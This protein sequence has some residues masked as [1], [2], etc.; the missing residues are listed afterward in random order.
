MSAAG[1]FL[2]RMDGGYCFWCPGCG[3]THYVGVERPLANG[4]AWSFDG[5]LEAP[6]FAPSILVMNASAVDPSFIHEPGDPPDICHSFI[7]QGRITFCAD[8]THELAGQTVDLPRW[9]EDDT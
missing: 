9:P 1:S 3:D 8:S 5:D 6:T 4:A 7:Q 2:R